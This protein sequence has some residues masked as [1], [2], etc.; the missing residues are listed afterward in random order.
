MHLHNLQEDALTVEH[1]KL[2]YRGAGGPERT[3]ER[4]AHVIFA[5]T[6]A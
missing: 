6:G 3:A 1:G 4:C 5:P 2:G